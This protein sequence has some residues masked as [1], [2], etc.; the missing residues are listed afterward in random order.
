MKTKGLLFKQLLLLFV[1]LVI[2]P[3]LLV[4]VQSEVNY[5]HQILGPEGK[6]TLA[7]YLTAKKLN[8]ESGKLEIIWDFQTKKAPFLIGGPLTKPILDPQE[9]TDTNKMRERIINFLVR[10]KALYQMD[11]P[12]EE[13][14]SERISQDEAAFYLLL[15]QKHKGLTVVGGELIARV[16]PNGV[17]DNISGH[18]FPDVELETTPQLGF[19]QARGVMEENLRQTLTSPIIPELLVFNANLLKGNPG[20][21]EYH[22][23]WRI[24]ANTWIYFIEANTGEIL[25]KYRNILEALSRE[26]YLTSSDGR[27]YC[28]TLWAEEDGPVGGV[29]DVA[30]GAA[31][32]TYEKTA[33]VYNYFR[34]NHGLD[35][36]DG[37]G[38]KMVACVGYHIPE[39]SSDVNCNAH[40]NPYSKYVHFGAGNE[41]EQGRYGRCS[42]RH[43]SAATDVVGHEWTHAVVTSKIPNFLYAGESG[44]LQESFSDFFGEVIEGKFDWQ[45]GEDLGV[46]IRDLANPHNTNQPEHMSEVGST[47]PHT[48][49]GIPNKVAYLLSVGGTHRGIS[50][51]RV[52]PENLAKLYFK[53]FNSLTPTT[54]FQD[55]RERLLV[56]CADFTDWCG[57]NQK[58]AIKNA[59]A[60]VGIGEP[61]TP[62]AS[63]TPTPTITPGGPTLTPTPTSTVTPT[64]PP[65]TPTP[66]FTPTPQPTYSP[67]PTATITPTL[68]P[69]E[70]VMFLK[71]NV[72]GALEDSQPPILI[73]LIAKGVN[74]SSSFI[75]P[76]KGLKEDF[77]LI[78]LTPG[79]TY[80]FLLSSPGYL[81]LKKQ[82]IILREG[83]NPLGDY[84]DF[85]TLRP[86]DINLDNQI[87]GLDWSFM[88]EN[89]GSEG[90]YFQ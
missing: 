18:Y 86:G 83:R 82:D 87:N 31:R 65:G 54:K 49:A 56:A 10:N 33:Q 77:R 69:G 51:E 16:R 5:Y 36:Y 79:K 37:Q 27:R 48:L 20:R 1:G 6:I 72:A 24:E 53:L 17:V 21:E 38:S 12:P 34:Q 11:N 64:F 8:Y 74:F 75:L 67:R 2:L 15:Q 44:A 59:F 88:H 71:V 28:A 63:G 29:Q 66:T 13:L 73:T 35:S 90:E 62:P 32:D 39:G 3:F 9:A 25:L 84:L 7:Q 89:F 70:P 41:D 58:A 43:F 4:L 68:S 50:V 57:E 81:T 52:G 46:L 42:R 26:V 45:A 78:G 23:S 80:D 76:P 19:E 85:G 55:F 40:W 47:E 22:L 30:G 14:A 61:V 60:S